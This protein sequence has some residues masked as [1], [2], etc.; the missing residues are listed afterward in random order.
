MK[1]LK[2]LFFTILIYGCGTHEALR[3]E[4]L[5]EGIWRGTLKMQ[6]QELPFNFEVEREDSVTYLVRLINGE[7]RIDIKGLAM[8]GD[9][10]FIPMHIFDAGIKAKLFG[11]R[12]VG[13]YEKHY[14][15]EY[16]LPFEATHNQKFRFSFND[17]K[18]QAD[19]SGTW[20]VVFKG[21]NDTTEALG[22]FSQLGNEVTGTFIT[23]TGDYRFLEG[24]AQDH[25]LWLSTFDGEH[26]FLFKADQ[27]DAQ[28]L[29][30]HFW[31]GHNEY[32]SWTARKNPQATVPEAA[33]IHVTAPTSEPFLFKFPDLNGKMVSVTDDRYQNQVK[34]VHIFGS[35]CPNSLDQIRFLADYYVKNKGRNVTVIGLAFEQKNDFTYAKNRLNKMANRLNAPYDFL[36]AGTA[37]LNSVQANLKLSTLTT[38][39]ST[40]VLDKKNRIRIIKNGFI[41]PG[42]GKIHEE[43]IKQF[44]EEVEKILA[45]DSLNN[46]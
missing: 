28:L 20:D 5:E 40:I 38:F 34:I 23:P 42:S 46:I 43:Y 33:R 14:D 30:G 7:E 4:Y 27:K 15:K 8:Q 29:E 1:V 10:V 24:T 21:E 35:W 32:K 36:L 26:A 41:G 12:M 45:E 9:S 22:I 25:T 37:D 18:S 2:A 19:F 13:I 39:P 11:R 17:K 31:S 16:K 6:G 3:Q 44:K